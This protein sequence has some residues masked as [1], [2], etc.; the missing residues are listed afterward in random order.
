MKYFEPVL[1]DFLLKRVPSP[2]VD[3]SALWRSEKKKQVKL[4]ETTITGL[5][6]VKEAFRFD[7]P[8]NGR[9]ENISIT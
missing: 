6:T 3:S 4:G 1:D 5:R 7:D 8:V 2:F 9:P